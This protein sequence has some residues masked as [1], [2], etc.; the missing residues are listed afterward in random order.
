M[1]F[2]RVILY[3]P[4]A[5]YRIPFSFRRRL[6]Y[7]LPPY[8]TV[9]GFLCNLCGIDDQ[10]KREYG[11]LQELKISVC[12]RLSLK[13]TEYVWFRNLSNKAHIDYYDSQENREKNGWIGHPGGL[14]PAQIDV[15]NDVEVVI[16]LYHK[17]ENVI[18][19]FE[20]DLKNPDKRLG[21]I[22]LG[23]AEDLVVFR[24]IKILKDEELKYGTIDGSY[25]YFFWVPEE[26]YIP[27]EDKWETYGGYDGI[28]YL[29]STFSKV[30]D[31]E[32]SRIISNVRTY[33]R[34]KAKLI[35]G[36]IVRKD[37]LMDK[38]LNLPVFLWGKNHEQ[39]M[40]KKQRYNP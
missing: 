36:T 38:E 30:K 9:I 31:Y 4:Q 27:F 28:V 23:R 24:E 12:G 11:Y 20:E 33:E 26:F 40:G 21:V 22:H 8:S 15:L 16:Y 17:Y 1:P 5:H 7:P 29:L 35:E 34:I 25:E 13:T 39:S 32:N 3:Q 6:T 14:G 19:F 18:S 10:N 2:L 37:G